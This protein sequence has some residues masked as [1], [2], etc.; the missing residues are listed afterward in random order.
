MSKGY[1]IPFN[2][3]WDKGN[4][5]LRLL[6]NGFSRGEIAGSARR[7][8][9]TVGDLE[10]VVEAQIRP[11]TP[12]TAPTD[13]ID[14]RLGELLRSDVLRQTT[15]PSWGPRLKKVFYQNVKVDIFIVQPDRQWGPTLLLRTGPSD[16]NRIMVTPIGKGGIMPKSLRWE[17][18]ALWESAGQLDTPEE[19][20]VFRAYGLPYIEPTTRT[21]KRLMELAGQGTPSWT[22][23]PGPESIQPPLF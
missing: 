22:L 12:Q 20:D 1:R 8:E 4:A 21:W 9:S 23:L 18:G 19:E 3:A 17:N 14:M 15:P 5:L 11:G 16:F 13:L 10:L 2:E 7:R 6:H